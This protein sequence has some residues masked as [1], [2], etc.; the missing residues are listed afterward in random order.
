VLTDFRDQGPCHSG[1]TRNQDPGDS[2]DF[3]KLS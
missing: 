3:A 2:L 1:G